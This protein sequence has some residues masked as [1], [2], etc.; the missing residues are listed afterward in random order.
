M[1]VVDYAKIKELLPH[2]Y[3]F[4]MVDRIEDLVLWESAKGIKN[5]TLN[6]PVFQ[7]HFPEDPIFP[8]VLIIEALAQT[9][10]VLAL[11]SIKSVPNADNAEE[12]GF[13]GVG[14]QQ[15]NAENSK[16]QKLVYFMTIDSAKFR[17]PVRPGD[18]IELNV[19]K[20]QM[21]GNVWRFR[22]NAIVKGDLMAEA[23]F[24]AMLGKD[25]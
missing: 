1:E 11:M 2:R 15:L 12:N 17:K 9:S 18:S 24:M 4:L 23:C 8:G 22:G 16:K 25:K 7:G 21:R 19:V 13:A 14:D 10:A 3:P 5:V 6:E 20:E